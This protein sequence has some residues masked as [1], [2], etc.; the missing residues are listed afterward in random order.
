MS[1]KWGDFKVGLKGQQQKTQKEIRVVTE[2]KTRKLGRKWWWWWCGKD[3]R[4]KPSCT[5]C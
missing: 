5:N 3:V 1:A 4:R 2:W